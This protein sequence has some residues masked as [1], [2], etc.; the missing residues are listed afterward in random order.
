MEAVQK[1]Q[2]VQVLTKAQFVIVAMAVAAVVAFNV[3]F[4]GQLVGGPER[5]ANG[6]GPLGS[7]GGTGAMGFDPKA[8]HPPWTVGVN[9]CL[10]QGQQPAV[11]DGSVNPTDIAGNYPPPAVDFLGAYV[12]DFTPNGENTPLGAVEGFPP[13]F[14]D[15]LY[16][17]KGYQV[18]R[19][20]SQLTQPHSP[21]TE[22]LI[23][24]GPD[25]VNTRGGGWLGIDVGYTSG[26]RHHVVSI[27]AEIMM[28]G[29]LAPGFECFAPAPSPG[30]AG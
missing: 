28:C 26:W 17:V 19:L 27:E 13:Q 10:A 6:D 20:C 30:V 3:P 15:K 25:A 18:T 14:P 21:Y 8:G 23:G 16:P 1:P 22:L 11:L 4:V 24:V 12:R 9:L 29:E 5:H 2:A 7:R